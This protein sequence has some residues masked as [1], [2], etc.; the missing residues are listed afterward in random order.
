MKK[1]FTLIELLIVVVIMGLLVGGAA[2]GYYGFNNRQKL[3]SAGLTL[4]N[5]LREAQSKAFNGEKSC[6]A[7]CSACPCRSQ[8]TDKA[9]IGWKVDFGS[10]TTY[11]TCGSSGPV[12]FSSSTFDLRTNVTIPVNPGVVEFLAYPKRAN[13]ST[14]ANI[15]VAMSGLTN[16]FYKLTVDPSGNIRDFGIVSPSCP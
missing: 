9:L 12:N 1:G 14:T 16:Q 4:K 7:C 5:V 13:I 6:T 11:G 3:K 8:P 15:C 2:T 10:R